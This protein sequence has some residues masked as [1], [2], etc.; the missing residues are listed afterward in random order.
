M[1]DDA[2]VAENQAHLDAEA[3][4]EPPNAEPEKW[5][6]EVLDGETHCPICGAPRGVSVPIE[7][8]RE[9]VR[10]M[11]ER[12]YWIRTPGT[13]GGGRQASVPQELVEAILKEHG[14]S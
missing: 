4:D 8:V 11:L 13:K 10:E 12:T 6:R 2:E 5:P 14:W 7:E 3:W 9:M 1:S